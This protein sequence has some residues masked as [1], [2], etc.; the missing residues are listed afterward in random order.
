M[1]IQMNSV[2]LEK[3]EPLTVMKSEPP[4][5]EIVKIGI[6]D[7]LDSSESKEKIILDVKDIIDIVYHPLCKDSIKSETIPENV[8]ESKHLESVE[9]IFVKIENTPFVKIE[10]V[11]ESDILNKTVDIGDSNVNKSTDQGVVEVQGKINLIQ[12]NNN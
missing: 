7:I 12:R 6:K 1:S 4:E 11:T 8:L 9:T 10:N 2:S 3:T 5:A